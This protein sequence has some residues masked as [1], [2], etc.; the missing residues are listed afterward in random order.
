MALNPEM[1]AS[2]ADRDRV[3]AALREHC[4]QGRISMEELNERLDSVYRARTFGEL[5]KVT[6][7]LP[8]HDMYELPVPASR[9]ST[10]ARRG[11]G[12]LARSGMRSAWAGYATVN[13]ICFVIWLVT[14]M[15]GGAWYPWFLWVAG[16]WGAVML[17]AQLF[18]ARDDRR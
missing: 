10:P 15:S 17:A 1:R 16:P 18:E 11:S 4:A 8:E 12:H 13:L 6:G 7:D 3:A 5:D 14:A 9:T 2:D